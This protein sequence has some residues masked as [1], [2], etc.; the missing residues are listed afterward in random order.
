MTICVPV[1]LKRQLGLRVESR[2]PA[3]PTLAPTGLN[4]VGAD[5]TTDMRYVHADERLAV[6][7]NRPEDVRIAEALHE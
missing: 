5:C 2:L 6:N 1:D 4:V 3:D 7:V